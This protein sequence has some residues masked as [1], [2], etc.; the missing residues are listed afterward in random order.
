[1]LQAARMDQYRMRLR[2]ETA[3]RYV[4][5]APVEV[6]AASSALAEVQDRIRRHV[7]EIRQIPLLSLIGLRKP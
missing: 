6:H 2:L 7:T 3:A 4:D 1:V 5:V